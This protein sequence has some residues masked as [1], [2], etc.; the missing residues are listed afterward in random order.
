MKSLAA[1]LCLGLLATTAQ[2]DIWLCLGENDRQSIQDKPCGKGF[3]TKSHVPDS[4]RR[5]VVASRPTEAAA[6]PASKTPIEVGLQRNKGVIC[7]L[8][9]T[10][11]ADA[12]AQIG[13][14]AAAPPGENPQD[15]L[16]K[17]EKQRTRV[18][19]DAG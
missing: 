16:V 14:S 3:R 18:G 4:P 13:G 7:N 6:R 5:G 10:E 15:N 19:C 11:K 17:I 1:I 2:A 8:L 9:N 12:L